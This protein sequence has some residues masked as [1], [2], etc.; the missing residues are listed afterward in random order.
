MTTNNNMLD[1]AQTRH[2]IKANLNSIMGFA[3]LIKENAFG[4]I[5]NPRYQHYINFI[6][7]SSLKI[8][9]II[10][11]HKA[12]LNGTEKSS[13]AEK[14]PITE[15][16]FDS[17]EAFIQRLCQ[18][19]YFIEKIEG[20]SFFANHSF[21]IKDE[22]LIFLALSTKTAYNTDLINIIPNIIKAKT[23]LSD[24]NKDK[25]K[26]ILAE[27]IPNAIIH[28]NLN[29]NSLKGNDLESFKNYH[30]LIKERLE[31]KKYADKFIIIKLFWNK[32]FLLCSVLDEG[33]GHNK[34]FEMPDLTSSSG[35]GLFIVSSLS[36]ATWFDFGGRG[37][38]FSLILNRH[39]KK[40]FNYNKKDF[41]Y[42]NSLTSIPNIY[43]SKILVVD[44]D[45]N[46]RFLIKDILKKSGFKNILKARS[47]LDGIKLAIYFKPDLIILDL[48]MKPLNGFDTLRHIKNIEF[49]KNIPVLI[50][51]GFGSKN[52]TETVFKEGAS[53]YIS[54]PI[55]NKEL[56][57]RCKIHLQN[58]LLIKTLGYKLS[59]IE[60]DISTA[61]RMQQALLPM[62]SVIADIENQVNF[63]IFHHFEPS[64]FLGGDLWDIIPLSK[65]KFAIYLVDFAG[66]GVSGSLNTFRLK[67]I[68][69]QISLKHSKPSEVLNHINKDLSEQLSLG[70]FATFIYAVFDKDKETLTYASAGSPSAFIGIK[71][72]TGYNFKF[73][74]HKEFP[75][76]IKKKHKYSDHEI[77]F[78]KGSFWLAYSD[79]LYE[80]ST[81]DDTF[82]EKCDFFSAFETMPPIDAVNKLKDCLARPVPDDLTVI[83]AQS[84]LV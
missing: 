37:I 18:T 46:T 1:D 57:S 29:V 8:N 33:Q 14:E 48:D 28:G 68:L 80:S 42:A 75:L 63:N 6:Y 34:T 49:L 25:L 51:T 71:E 79:A 12:S 78:P 53:D 45:Q 35:R 10:T 4:K 9:D 74:E 27:I 43:K 83:L 21:E 54:K 24:E 77:D 39:N 17:E 11:N 32:G 20:H 15:D 56:I 61:S 38:C 19:N 36:D 50:Q 76:G 13:S 41:E 82:I 16:Y 22:N 3:E 70:N 23:K 55:N 73:L 5:N 40:V 65:N 60:A 52:V 44:D 31:N 62:N 59:N 66:H 69:N 58:R 26:Q 84:R 2:D 7:E 72:E 30:N 64:A 47:G 81:I 67:S